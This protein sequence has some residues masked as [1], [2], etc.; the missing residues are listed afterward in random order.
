MKSI[1]S[2]DARQ[3]LVSLIPEICVRNELDCVAGKLFEQ[4][5]VNGKNNDRTS[6]AQKSEEN[7]NFSP[8]AENGYSYELSNIIKNY[9]CTIYNVLFQYT[10]L[11]YFTFTYLTGQTIQ[12]L[13]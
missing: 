9:Y 7:S 3:H 6:D 2:V 10:F 8:L 12:R 4:K 5:G 13:V 11:H 1:L